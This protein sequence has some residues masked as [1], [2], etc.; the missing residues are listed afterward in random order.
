MTEPVLTVFIQSASECSRPFSETATA[1]ERI[2]VLTN[3]ESGQD[4]GR[5]ITQKSK[6][7]EIRKDAKN[8]KRVYLWQRDPN[9]QNL[10]ENEVRS[11]KKAI[12]CKKQRN[13]Y[14]A[15]NEELK[16]I[17]RNQKCKI[18]ELEAVIAL[19]RMSNCQSY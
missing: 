15:K 10:S 16:E 5:R 1:T 17:V 13:K 8:S 11:I 2:S 9:E 19:L 3:R 18:K 6:K 12:K 14:K 4:A 7:T